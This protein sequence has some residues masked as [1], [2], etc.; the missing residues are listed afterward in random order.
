[1]SPNRPIREADPEGPLLRE[2]ALEAKALSDTI[3]YLDGILAWKRMQLR[4]ALE[5]RGLRSSETVVRGL[6]MQLRPFTLVVC[7]CHSISAE[8]CPS[9]AAGEAIELKIVTNGDYLQL[10]FDTTFPRR[11]IPRFD[12]DIHADA[13]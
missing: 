11:G 7:A 3:D 8:S 2:I 12:D 9:A 13:A 5:K 10:T 4:G 1:V 6:R